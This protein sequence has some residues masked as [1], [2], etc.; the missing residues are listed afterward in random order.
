MR[1]F[2]RAILVFVVTFILGWIYLLITGAKIDSGVRHKALG[3][4]PCPAEG[5]SSNPR[6]QALD[7]LKNRI[8]PDSL[9]SG[10]VPALSLSA[11]FT[12]GDDTK[13]FSVT[14]YVTII[15]YI[16]KVK[17][18]E[19]ETC[20]CHSADKT[21]WD[22]HIEV[23][24]NANISISNRHIMICEVNR[25]NR[26][27]DYKTLQSYVGKKV[28]LTGYLFFDEEHT[29]AAETTHPGGV[30]NWRWTCWELH[31]VTQLQITN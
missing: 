25:Y 23:S 8:V 15:G 1:L 14:Q 22:Y 24:D 11:L 28:T 30:H 13:R 27:I 2:A 12:P 16:V 10:T 3:V 5:G 20:N 19:A 4:S 31:P 26:C 18:G 6:L 29:N 17:Y 9:S 7:R 21:T